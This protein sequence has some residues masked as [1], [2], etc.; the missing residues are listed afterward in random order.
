MTRPFVTWVEHFVL[1]R[2]ERSLMSV[3][4][5]AF[6]KIKHEYCTETGFKE[7]I[8]CT[9]K[10]GAKKNVYRRYRWLHLFIFVTNY[11]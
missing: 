9:F 2:E 8:Q 10:N 5:F 3:H 6:Q 11:Y 1:C 4:L 7:H